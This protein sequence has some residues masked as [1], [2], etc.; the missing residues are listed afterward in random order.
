[1]PKQNQISTKILIFSIADF[2]VFDLCSV[3]KDF[4]GCQLS[5]LQCR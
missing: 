3:N 5:M 2:T 4:N 1:M